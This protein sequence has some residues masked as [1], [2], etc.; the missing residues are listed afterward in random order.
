MHVQAI[1]WS[2][3]LQSFWQIVYVD[4]RWKN[5]SETNIEVSADRPISIVKSSIMKKLVVY[6]A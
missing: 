5:L 6:H 3:F 2:L 1:V 4:L